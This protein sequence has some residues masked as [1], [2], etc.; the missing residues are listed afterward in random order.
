MYL[1]EYEPASQWGVMRSY[2]ATFVYADGEPV[3]V[4]DAAP[5]PEGGE[6]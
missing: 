5:E 3:D 4:E 6:G 2:G 1:K